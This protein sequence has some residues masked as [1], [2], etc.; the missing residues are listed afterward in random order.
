MA[1]FETFY[2]KLNAFK[3]KI[4]ILPTTDNFRKRPVATALSVTF[5]AGLAFAAYV[6]SAN[7]AVKYSKIGVEFVAD[8][9]PQPTTLEERMEGNWATPGDSTRV[10]KISKDLGFVDT[11]VE[12][13]RLER[14]VGMNDVYFFRYARGGQCWQ[15]FETIDRKTMLLSNERAKPD[16]NC[17]TGILKRV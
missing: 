3:D 11:K 9:M 5:F 17:I 7:S 4:V 10:L 2:N 16:A 14:V 15:K 6:D 12:G 1:T 13:G 8:R